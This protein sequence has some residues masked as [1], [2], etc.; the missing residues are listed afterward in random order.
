M[1]STRST[2]V[3]VWAF[4]GH[5]LL[6][7]WPASALQEVT[8]ANHSQLSN[9]QLAEIFAANHAGW[10]LD[11]VLLSDE[12]RAK[13]LQAARQIHSTIDEKSLW[14]GLVRL[15]KAGK[16][17]AETTQRSN[18]EYGEALPAAEIAAR[19]LQDEFKVSFDQILVDP[20]LLTKYDKLARGIDSESDTYTLRK[21]ALRLRKSRQL[22]PE[23]VTRVT[24]WNREI[25]T[26]TLDELKKATDQIPSRPGV[27]IFRDATGYLY[28][29]Q[30][31]N[32]RERLAKHLVE[33]DRASLAK[34][35]TNSSE[36]TIT[37]ELHIFREGSPAEQ[38]IV[39]EAYESEL[40]RSRKPK[41]NLAP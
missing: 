36:K 18:T 35:L 7:C 22:K 40:I 38:T 37:L 8:T 16:L 5:S 31:N 33:S 19:R 9:V 23:L 27:Y 3:F 14:E 2:W 30:S 39:R 6:L 29:G 13:V 20:D 10:S 15:R 1:I 21:A 34:Y 11:E 28:I 26:W 4:L 24:E 41:L 32:L 12:R 17:K 25:A